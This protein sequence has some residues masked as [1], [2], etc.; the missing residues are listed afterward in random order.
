M[1]DA[2]LDVFDCHRKLLHGVAY[3]ILGSVDEADDVVQETWLRWH[4]ADRAAVADPRAYLVRIATRAAFDHIRRAA[5]RRET[6]VGAWLPEPMLTEPDIA[7]DA[8]LADSISMAMLVLLQTLS[9]LERA[10]FVLKE[11]FGFTYPQISDAIGRSDQAVRQLAHRARQHIQA[12]QPRFDA[13]R[14]VSRTV[15]ERFMKA[16]IGGDLA[17]LLS[18]LAPE[19]TLIAD[20][21]G[22]TP[23]PRRPIHGAEKVA[24]FFA[25]TADNIPTG[26]LMRIV[27]INGGPGALTL[28]GATPYA[29]FSFHVGARTERIQTIHL[30]SNPDK[31]TRL[32]L[33]NQRAV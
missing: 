26:T 3:R 32:E 27:D 7:E 13:D 1:S 33:D 16:A 25:A 19:V 31:L 4:R 28:L 5:S 30:I 6:Y 10:V 23:G 21:G 11:A 24:R 22:K 14:N 17:A 15:T 12:R 20:S 8:A 2:V 18:V 9:P 29:A